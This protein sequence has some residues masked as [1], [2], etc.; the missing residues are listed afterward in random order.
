MYNH[1][2]YT[3]LVR[4]LCRLLDQ[5]LQHIRQRP[6]LRDEEFRLTSDSLLGAIQTV[7]RCIA[8]LHI[9]RVYAAWAGR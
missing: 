5:W 7:E 1:D 6:N 2:G 3:L 9:E 4:V 8:Q